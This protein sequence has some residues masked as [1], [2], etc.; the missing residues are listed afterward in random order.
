M[1][2]KEI[3]R[4]AILDTFDN[5]AAIAKAY[6]ELVVE[7]K[8]PN[9][10]ETQE[11]DE[12]NKGDAMSLIDKVREAQEESYDKW[13]DR[14]FENENL[15]DQ[16]KQSAMKGYTSYR[17]VINDEYSEYQQ[18][19]MNDS[20]FIEKLKD[21]LEGFKI[22]RKDPERYEVSLF[23]RSAGYRWTKPEVIISWKCS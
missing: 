12:E 17:Y 21:K 13:F 2:K 20:R 7:G 5:A 15:E 6:A 4:E 8:I 11:M 1:N 9:I 3:A 18:R 23:G 22:Y 10:I 14:W 16:L 19:R